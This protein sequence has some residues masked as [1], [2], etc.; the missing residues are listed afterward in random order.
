MSC[1]ICGR[2]SCCAIRHGGKERLRFR[3]VIEAFNHA[4]KLRTELNAVLDE[5][6]RKKEDRVKEN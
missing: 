5:E 3:E 4:R 6:A 2:S 1:D